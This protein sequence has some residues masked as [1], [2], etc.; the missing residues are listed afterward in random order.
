MRK[1]KI[2]LT[3]TLWTD[4]GVEMADCSLFSHNLFDAL[5]LDPVMYSKSEKLAIVSRKGVL[6]DGNGRF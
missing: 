5:F 2:G 1:N 3:V 4:L 6:G